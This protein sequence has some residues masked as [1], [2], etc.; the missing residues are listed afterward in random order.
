MT[1]FV[2]KFRHIGGQIARKR[3]AVPRHRMDEAQ[4]CRV[5][6]LAAELELLQ[7]GPEGRTGP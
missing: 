2:D 3:Q 5:E 4:D 7:E 1:A 6:G